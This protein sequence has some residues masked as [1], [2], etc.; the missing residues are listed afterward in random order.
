M[1]IDS[2]IKSSRNDELLI[3]R[4]FDAPRD[5]VFRMWTEARHAVNWWGPRHHPAVHMEMDV[6]P[7]GKWR[8]C[9]RGVDD[10]RELWHHGTFREVMPPEKLVFTFAWEEDGERGQETLVTITF[11][12]EGDRTKMV[13][14]HAPFLSV[15]ERDGHTEGW[16]SAFDRLADHL[17]RREHD[18]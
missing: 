10:G 15:G 18:R 14:H 1:T 12:E 13:F 8:H 17:A 5:L 16:G 4:V 6:R 11:T 3:T 2:D 7:G 9:L